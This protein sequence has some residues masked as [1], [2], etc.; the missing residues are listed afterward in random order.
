MSNSPYST[1][2]SCFGLNYSC[3][4]A[5]VTYEDICKIGVFKDQTIIAVR[6]PEETKLEVPTPTEVS[7]KA[8]SLLGVLIK[9]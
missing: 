7:L 4:S 5:Y 8:Q 9:K 6:A 1:S 3:T 2:F